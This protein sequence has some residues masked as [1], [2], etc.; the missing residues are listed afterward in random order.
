MDFVLVLWFRFAESNQICRNC[1]V[2]LLL[3]ISC[4]CFG[5]F[6]QSSIYDSSF[7]SSGWIGIWFWHFAY[8]LLHPCCWQTA[9]W[10][11]KEKKKRLM[12]FISWFCGDWINSI[13]IIEFGSQVLSLCLF[14][15]HG[16]CYGDNPLIPRLMCSFLNGIYVV[17][18]TNAYCLGA[19]GDFTLGANKGL[20]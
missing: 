18:F 11:V 17:L 10:K 1:F 4:F 16:C 19:S 20:N 9:S 6:S 14:L 15:V 8:L 2:I 13:N 3:D 7:S 5:W 12:Q